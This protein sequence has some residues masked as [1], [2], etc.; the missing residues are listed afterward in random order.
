M[1]EFVLQHDAKR[2]REENRNQDGIALLLWRFQLR[3]CWLKL[4]IEG[5][6]SIKATKDEVY[7]QIVR[8]LKVE[9]YPMGS[10]ADFKEASVNDLVLLIISPIIEALQIRQIATTYDYSEKNRLFRRTDRPAVTKSLL[11]L[12][13]SQSQK[14]SISSLSKQKEIHLVQQ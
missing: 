9:G 6:D 14:K 13:G 4:D 12:I 8:Y 1:E 5:P 3:K 11:Q 7:K 2:G 10:N